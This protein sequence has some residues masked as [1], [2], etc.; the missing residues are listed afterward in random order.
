MGAEGSTLAR[1]AL[2]RKLQMMRERAKIKQAGAARIIGVSPQGIGRLEEGQSTRLANDLFMNALCDAY[3]A[4]QEERRVILALAQE[5]RDAAKK[6]GGW[7]RAYADQITGG[8]DHF[9]ALEE[10]A[11]KLTAWKVM[12]IPGLL[13][14]PDY[15]RAI[16]WTE[17]PNLPTEQI[18]KR[19]EWSTRRQKR[20]EDP[21]FTANILLSEAA[22]REEVG[23]PGV[24]KGQLGFLADVGTLPNVSVRVVPFKARSHLGALVGSFFLM[25]FPLLQQT[26]LV[27]P[28][29]VYVEEYAG[30]LYLEREEE[31]QRYQDAL[32]E[33]GR[34]ALGESDSR[35]MILALAKEYGE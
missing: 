8:F 7:W 6:G 26:K 10:A 1:R 2:G 19:I 5:V 20:L 31:V 24:M 16:A 18:E 23:G 17:S 14:T 9:L 33:L 13:Q 3:G 11:I 21:S 27:Q 30:D 15:R 32:R 34:V 4:T 12:V 28:P 22:L 35:R 29:I 25:E